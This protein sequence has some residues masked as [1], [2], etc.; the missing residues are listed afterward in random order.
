MLDPYNKSRIYGEHK[1][2]HTMRD[3]CPLVRKQVSYIGLKSWG[4]YTVLYKK[5]N[6]LGSLM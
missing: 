1:L 3:L 4:E 5:S 6:S 2:T